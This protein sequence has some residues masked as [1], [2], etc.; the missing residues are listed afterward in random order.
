MKFVSCVALSFHHQYERDVIMLSNINKLIANPIINSGYILDDEPLLFCPPRWVSILAVLSICGTLLLAVY[1]YFAWIV[2]L[3][4]G[5][6]SAVALF[7]WLRTGYC[8][9]ARRRILPVYILS[10]IAM[11]V[12]YSELHNGV[13]V[14]H[15]ISMFPEVFGDKPGFSQYWFILTFLLMPASVFLWAA[16]GIFYHKLIANYVMWWLYIWCIV[17]PVSHYVLPVFSAGPYGYMPGMYSAPLIVL[18]GLAGIAAVVNE[19]MVDG[20]AS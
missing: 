13:Y 19:N 16:V 6:I 18:V 10:V 7:A 2:A 11:L 8:Q 20:G 17:F 3:L 15:L 12:H 9:P 14:E 1:I 5:L 4:F